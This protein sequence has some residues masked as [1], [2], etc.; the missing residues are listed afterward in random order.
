MKYGRYKRKK[1][2]ENNTERGN[3]FRTR[4]VLRGS[5]LS[6]EVMRVDVI[7]CP[8]KHNNYSLIVGTTD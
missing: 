8:V 1:I 2:L 4:V 7:T 5:E 3:T 6:E